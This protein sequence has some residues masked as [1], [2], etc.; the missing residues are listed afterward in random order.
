M[1]HWNSPRKVKVKNQHIEFFRNLYLTF[2]EYDGNLLRRELFGCNGQNKP[3]AIV[4]KKISSLNEDDDCFEFRREGILI[5]RTHLYYLDYDYVPIENDVTLVAQL[6]MDR[7]QM[8]E[9]IC[10][11]WVGPMSIALY[12]SD[13]EAQQFLRFALASSILMSRRNIGYHIVYKD[14]QFYP[15]NHLRNIAL[16]QVRTPYVFLADI[17]FLP[18]YG[19]Y[20]YLRKTVVELDLNSNFKKVSYPRS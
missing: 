15:V 8:L 12:M 17:D 16:R 7:L 9:T 1:I 11:H 4:E 10:K 6:S 20:E 13:G 18:M 5:Y 19:L 2:L 3:L 14:G